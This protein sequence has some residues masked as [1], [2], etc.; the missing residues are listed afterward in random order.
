[1]QRQ[2][3]FRILVGVLGGLSAVAAGTAGFGELPLTSRILLLGCGAALTGVCAFLA[4]EAPAANGSK[5]L[6]DELEPST[7]FKKS[8]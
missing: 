7:V 2:R 3:V 1:M 5:S 6:V 4:T 8:S